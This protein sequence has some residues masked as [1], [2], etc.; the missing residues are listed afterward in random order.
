MNLLFPLE[1]ILWKIVGLND[2]SCKAVTG[3]SAM[4]ESYLKFLHMMRQKWCSGL[5]HNAGRQQGLSTQFLYFNE[6]QEF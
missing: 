2:L 5:P 3:V 4:L 6:K 1:A